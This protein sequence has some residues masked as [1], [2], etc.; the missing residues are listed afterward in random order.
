VSTNFK[1]TNNKIIFLNKNNDNQLLLLKKKIIMD[2]IYFQIQSVFNLIKKHL[3]FKKF[4]S[5]M[6]L[7]D[8]MKKRKVNFL[9]AEFIYDKFQ[10][11]M[12]NISKIHA[13]FHKLK[14]SKFFLKWKNY[15][16][17]RKKYNQ[18]KS[19]IEK[20]SEKIFEKELKILESKIKEKEEDNSGAKKTLQKNSEIEAAILK[21]ISEFEEK[22]SNYIKAI[23]KL[24]EEKK[25]IQE[26]IDLIVLESTKSQSILKNINYAL[27]RNEG[28]ANLEI[29]KNNNENNYNSNFLSNNTSD[30]QRKFSS[31]NSYKNANNKI[32]DLEQTNSFGF[33]KDYLQKLQE[34][35]KEK[36]SR[37]IKLRQENSEKDQKINVFMKE[38]SELIHSHENNSIYISTF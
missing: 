30:N 24:E 29:N 9:K 13:K 2:Q 36:E 20:N 6:D 35:I 17:F 28:K 3:D 27:I 11:M 37:I 33:K 14:F 38:M 4:K 23:R 26:E 5:F 34:K 25:F 32:T 1:N 7:K 22:E 19:E 12:L 16:F 10:N 15:A 21:T 8:F 31:D 18:L